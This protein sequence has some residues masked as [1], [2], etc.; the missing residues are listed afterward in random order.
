MNAIIGFT[1]IAMKHS[2][3]PVDIAEVSDSVITIMYGYLSNRD[4]T[5]Q[6]EL[7]EPQAHYVLTDA[8]RVREVLVNILG[9]AVKFTHDGGIVTYSASYHPGK[10]DRYINVRYR[11]SDTGIGMSE[12]FMDHIFDEF[13]QEERGA[14]TQ[15]K[16]T[17][18]G[19]TITKQYV[20]MMGGYDFC[21]EQ[22]GRWLNFY[23]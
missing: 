17:G 9:N 20:D 3:T 19:M 11:I 16:G 5:F 6:T 10:D 4:I 2:P 23:R 21:G 1:N 18:L 15:Y 7:E 14:R 13:S 8:V 12:E 22:E